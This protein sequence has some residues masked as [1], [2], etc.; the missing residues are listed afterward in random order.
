MSN[1]F[2]A[3]Q[4]CCPG[5]SG[6]NPEYVSACL[7]CGHKKPIES[8]SSNDVVYPSV[9]WALKQGDRCRNYGPE[10]TRVENENVI[11][12]LADEVER[13]QEESRQWEK[14]SLVGLSE[15]NKRLHA[16]IES[17]E[18]AMGFEEIPDKPC[19]ADITR[20]C[21]LPWGH[22]GPHKERAAVETTSTATAEHWEKQARSWHDLAMS[23]IWEIAQLRRQRPVET[24]AKPDPTAESYRL[25]M[26]GHQAKGIAEFCGGEYE[27]DLTVGYFESAK[28][29]ETG[30]EMPGGLYVWCS[31]YAEEGRVFLP[32]QPD[33]TAE[34]AKELCV[35]G[36]PLVTATC[37]CAAPKTTA[38][39]EA[40]PF[41]RCT[42]CGIDNAAY[43]THCI[44][45]EY[46]RKHTIGGI[47][48]ERSCT[49]HPCVC[50]AVPRNAP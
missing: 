34:K 38:S 45:C 1:P 49:G 18:R 29:V 40:H 3:E 31:E 39:R 42:Q 26:T 36:T 14:L 25:N 21:A 48:H 44:K 46:S 47:L 50:D 12:I 41:W 23:Q 35:H 33:S 19:H 16:V 43:E 10:H 9:E 28:D 20:Y 22:T 11:V 6:F 30:E 5:C 4:W 27:V 8:V 37:G 2:T 7:G 15:E 24:P 32:M 13:L 17:R